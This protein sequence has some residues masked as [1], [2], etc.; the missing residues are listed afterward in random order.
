MRAG[1]PPGGFGVSGWSSARKRHRRRRS[2]AGPVRWVACVTGRRTAHRRRRGPN[3]AL[4]ARR[5][6]LAMT[7]RSD[8]RLGSALPAGRLAP[9]VGFE[10]TTLRLTAPK[11]SAPETYG[12]VLPSFLSRLLPSPS[13]TPP[14]TSRRSSRSTRTP[15]QFKSADPAGSFSLSSIVPDGHGD[16]YF[17]H[18]L[19]LEDTHRE[20][21]LHR[22]ADRISL[23]DL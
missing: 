5:G 13:L 22:P 8:S 17:G 15:H 2:G 19:R 21:K 23:F 1:P 12:A 11:A 3:P 20:N 9:Q 14:D 10:P 16:P 7:T 6:S 4:S 18:R